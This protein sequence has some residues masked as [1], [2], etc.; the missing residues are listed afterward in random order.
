MY[1]IFTCTFI[2]FA[3]TQGTFVMVSSSWLI[4]YMTFD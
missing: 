4:G 1:I 2:S 3:Q